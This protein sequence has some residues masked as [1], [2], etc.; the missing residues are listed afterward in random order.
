MPNK[1]HYFKVRH[2]GCTK[3]FYTL[4]CENIIKKF[5]AVKYTKIKGSAMA[6][7]LKILEMYKRTNSSNKFSKILRENMSGM[8]QGLLEVHDEVAAHIQNALEDV[9]YIDGVSS[10][11]D[12]SEA[13]DKP[14]GEAGFPSVRGS[15]RKFSTK[16]KSKV[17][18]LKN[19]F[20]KEV[21]IFL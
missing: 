17:F 16:L 4:I 3:F 7:F 6:I 13:E 12:E 5:A 21:Y 2:K 19:L 20:G 8:A 15:W 14:A 10:S 18:L 11:G 9:Q 1:H